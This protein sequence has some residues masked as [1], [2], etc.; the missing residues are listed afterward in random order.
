[1]LNDVQLLDY[2]MV[3]TLRFMTDAFRPVHQRFSAVKSKVIDC[4]SWP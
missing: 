2:R 4:C 1:M 3:E